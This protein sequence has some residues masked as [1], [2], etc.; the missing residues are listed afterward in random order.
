MRKLNFKVVIILIIFL[1]TY[2]YY[3]SQSKRYN[4]D[5]AFF[6]DL[7]EKV[8]NWSFNKKA[9]IP[10]TYPQESNLAIAI[11]L[12]NQLRGHNGYFVVIK[13]QGAPIHSGPDKQTKII[14]ELNGGTRVRTLHIMQ[15]FNAPS[16]K[17]VFLGE[18][19]TGHPIG[20]VDY[21][22]LV[23][24]SDFKKVEEWTLNYFGFCKGE[25]CGEMNI[26]KNGFYENQWYARGQGLYLRGTY[27]G[28]LFEHDGIIW[29]KKSKPDNWIDLFVLPTGGGEIDHEYKYRD[30]K[31]RLFNQQA[32]LKKNN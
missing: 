30:Q 2:G 17:W 25:Y 4:Y 31:I 28:K 5:Y 15:D 8:M 19:E 1:F 14:S 13:E 27:Q 7:K 20:W 11:D 10:L 6:S 29:A 18:E 3:T 22:T 23:F 26:S 21:Q 9:E 12:T 16:V 32:R 24:K